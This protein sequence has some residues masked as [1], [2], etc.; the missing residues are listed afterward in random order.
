MSPP[1][2]ISQNTLKNRSTRTVEIMMTFNQLTEKFFDQVD[3]WERHETVKQ[4]EN[5]L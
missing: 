4:S 5:A 1:A 2:M 3:D